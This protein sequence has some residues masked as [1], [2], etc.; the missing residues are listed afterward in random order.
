MVPQFPNNMEFNDVKCEL[1]AGH[2]AIMFKIQPEEMEYTLFLK[3]E[4]GVWYPKGVQHSIVSQ[5]GFVECTYCN[6]WI[7]KSC[8]FLDGCVDELYE[9]LKKHPNIRVRLLFE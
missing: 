3:K 2:G 6:N 4:K 8:E 7:L 5:K 9:K 1:K